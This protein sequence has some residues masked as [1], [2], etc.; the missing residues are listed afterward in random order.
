MSWAINLID[1]TGMVPLMRIM[2]RTS[3]Q[4]SLAG[5]LVMGATYVLENQTV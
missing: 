4:K 3:S 1:M 5:R 2:F